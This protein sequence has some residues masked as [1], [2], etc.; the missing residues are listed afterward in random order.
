MGLK[1]L[2]K[3]LKKGMTLEEGLKK[4]NMT[5]KDIFANPKQN[6]HPPSAHKGTV[7]RNHPFSEH[8]CVCKTIH[9]KLVTFGTY[10]NKEEAEII[11]EKLCLVK[12]DKNELDNILKE[13]GI[14]R[15]LQSDRKIKE[16]TYIYPN[17]YGHFAISKSKKQ[18]HVRKNICG[19]T[20]SSFE[21]AKIIRDELIKN[22]WDTSN[23]DEICEKHG[24][25]RRKRAGE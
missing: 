10:S 4:H 22:D 19:G 17:K 7:R 12:W 14:K 16:N 5:L 3:D 1:S 25:K 2:Q 18:N 23:L 20:Y 21:D 15:V 6:P 8:Y 13:T 9:G 24:I 11:R